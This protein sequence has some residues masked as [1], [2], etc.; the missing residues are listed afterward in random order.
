MTFFVNYVE[1]PF[2]FRPSVTSSYD[3][4]NQKVRFLVLRSTTEVRSKIPNWQY[5]KRI[6]TSDSDSKETLHIE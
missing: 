4:N 2:Q 5:F 3:Y 6:D 1:E